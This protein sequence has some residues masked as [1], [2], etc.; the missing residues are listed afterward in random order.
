[1]QRSAENASKKDSPGLQPDG[2]CVSKKAVT[3]G[4]ADRA[5]PERSSGAETVAGDKED[6]WNS[7]EE[8]E[9]SDSKQKMGAC[10]EAHQGT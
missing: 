6:V 7:A 5:R 1:M 4:G 9:A 10:G 2:E 3:V 8:K